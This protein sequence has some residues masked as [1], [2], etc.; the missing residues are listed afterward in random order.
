MLVYFTVHAR[1]SP[2]DGELLIQAYLPRK[3]KEIV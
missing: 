1:P 3:V 2:R